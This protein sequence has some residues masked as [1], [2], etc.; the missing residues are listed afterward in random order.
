MRDSTADQLEWFCR[1][2]SH[3]TKYVGAGVCEHCGSSKIGVQA[4]FLRKTRAMGPITEPDDKN[5]TKHQRLKEGFAI[6]HQ[7]G[8]L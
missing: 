7:A 4:D 6:L 3:L 1:A 5:P 8:D 2:C